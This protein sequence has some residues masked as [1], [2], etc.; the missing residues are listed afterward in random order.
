M[1]QVKAKWPLGVFPI[2]KTLEHG[3][4]WVFLETFYFTRAANKKRCS[5]CKKRHVGIQD[6]VHAGRCSVGVLAGRGCFFMRV[7]HMECWRPCGVRLSTWGIAGRWPSSGVRAL[8]GWLAKVS[9]LWTGVEVV[10]ATH[11][12]LETKW[13][14]G[15]AGNPRTVS[16]RTTGSLLLLLHFQHKCADVNKSLKCSPASC[17]LSLTWQMVA[18]AC[19]F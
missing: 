2:P 16:H 6:G 12:M 4:C 9:A 15:A 3:T 17:W 10:M 18:G 8:K 1:H 5:S 13:G 14:E 19:P 7:A 11:G